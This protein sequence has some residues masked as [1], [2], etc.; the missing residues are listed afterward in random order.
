M[1]L[2]AAGTPF[3]V[4]PSWSTDADLM[5]RTSS[6]HIEGG[7]AAVRARRS[8]RL[9]RGSGFTNR[10]DHIPLIA[11]L[12]IQVALMGWHRRRVFDAFRGSRSRFAIILSASC[13]LTL[14]R[15]LCGAALLRSPQQA[16]RRSSFFVLGW[17]ER[18]VQGWLK[19]RRAARPGGWFLTS[20]SQ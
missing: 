4:R 1:T 9:A 13:S 7:N 6:R 15:M 17:F 3:A 2:L 5:W 19:L 8:Q 11:V 20:T 12:L 10:V 14:T 16:K 18:S